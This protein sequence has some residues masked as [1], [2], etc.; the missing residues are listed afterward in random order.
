MSILIDNGLRRQL[1]VPAVYASLIFAGL[2]LRED[3]ARDI[4]KHWQVTAREINA[5]CIRSC[6]SEVLN[7]LATRSCVEH[8][9]SDVVS[10]IPG[11]ITYS[12]D[13]A[14]CNCLEWR[15]DCVCGLLAWRLDLDPQLSRRGFILPVTNARGWFTQLW[16]YRH[17]RDSRPFLLQTRREAVAA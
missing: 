10:R 7:L 16:V 12:R 15:P 13:P 11:V 1:E 3:T 9:G 6:P 14:L 2:T 5:L 4:E 8:F 17:A